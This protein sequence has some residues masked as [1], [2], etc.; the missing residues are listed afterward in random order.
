[1]LTKHDW[2]FTVEYSISHTYL[3]SRVSWNAEPIK[4][5]YS[6][7]FLENKRNR[8]LSRKWKFIKFSNVSNPNSNILR[9]FDPELFSFFN[10]YGYDKTYHTIA[11]LALSQFFFSKCQRTMPKMPPSESLAGKPYAI[12]LTRAC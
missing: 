7:S 4:Q 5:R 11:H 12:F 1:M 9:E 3:V 2:L 6:F 8:L 10:A